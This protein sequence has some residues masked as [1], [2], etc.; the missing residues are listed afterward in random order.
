[1]S[2]IEFPSDRTLLTAVSR[3]SLVWSYGGG[4]TLGFSGILIVRN[5]NSGLFFGVLPVSGLYFAVWAL[6]VA[7]MVYQRGLFLQATLVYET[8]LEIRWWWLIPFCS[9]GDVLIIDSMCIPLVG[10]TVA[11]D[12]T[13]ISY[14]LLLACVSPDF[15]GKKEGQFWTYCYNRNSFR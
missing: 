9:Q 4:L 14:S 10:F 7:A 12:S 15:I 2:V 11:S 1:M 13:P 6:T 3:W 8:S 5:V